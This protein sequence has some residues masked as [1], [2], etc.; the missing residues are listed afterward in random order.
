[1]ENEQ[2]SHFLKGIFPVV[3]TPLN[4]DESLDFA[5][6]SACL[7]FYMDSPIAG[8][9]V[10]GSGG[11]LPYLSDSEQL[12][13]VEHVYQSVGDAK[14][15]IVGV[16]AF[17]AH[18]AIDKIATYEGK[19]SAVMVL[20]NAYYKNDFLALK[21]AL[22]TVVES[23]SMPVLYYHFP[24]VSGL[25]LSPQQLVELLNETGVVGMK[26]SALHLKSARVILA[27]C[28]HCAYFSG[29]SLLLPELVHLGAAGAICPIGAIAPELSTKLYKSCTTSDEKAT[30]ITQSR[31]IS[32][33]P[34][35]NMLSMPPT[36]QF[37]LLRFV[38]AFPINLLKKAS[39]PQAASK[40]ALRL[41]G[42]DIGATVRR[43][44]PA[45]EE[46][47]S[48]LILKCLKEAGLM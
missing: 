2:S 19:A 41:L 4:E 34:I 10:L 23:S 28:S 39:S 24:Q 33:L 42:L 18:H 17:S 47:S 29:L 22:K 43:P 7:K 3:P 13:V 27:E 37:K 12:S 31:L 9:T 21:N 11:E 38:T 26:D 15:I 5:G 46:E 44:L 20:F 35:V 48:D 14:S 16:N 1:M 40:E 8:I 30:R 45:L 25:F 32:L 6:L 36:R